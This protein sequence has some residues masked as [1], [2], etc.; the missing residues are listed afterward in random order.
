MAGTDQL[1]KT[2]VVG[3]YAVPEWLANAKTDFFQRRLSRSVLDT[4]HLAALKAAVKDQE[5]A[6]I[7]VVTDGEVQRDNSLDYFLARLPGVDIDNRVKA[8]YLDFFDAVVRSA[9]SPA[10]LGLLEDYALVTSLTEQPIKCTITGAYS[11]VRRLRDEYYGSA[12]KMGDALAETIN[13]ELLRLQAAGCAYIQV[14]DEY[15]SGFPEEAG[16]AMKLLNR[17]LEG[18]HVH[19]A[20]HVCFGNR[21]GKPSWAGDYSYLLPAVLDA[22]IDQLTLEFAR[23]GYADLQ[24]LRGTTLPFELGL[25]VIDVKDVQVE[26]PE[27]V[28][29]RIVQATSYVR[30]EKIWVNP[31]CG[32]RHLSVD[33]ARAKLSAMVKGARLARDLV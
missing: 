26:T 24:A 16:W 27:L 13:G 6:G 14:D 8:Y 15:I 29:K 21:Y 4:I 23:R 28:A 22:H 17:S 10:P 18:I 12:Q 31:D 1:F 20:L 32:L 7:D 30:P 25:G 19:K 3:G 9:V 11:M 5:L 2:S 33:V